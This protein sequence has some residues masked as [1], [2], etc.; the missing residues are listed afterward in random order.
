[1]KMNILL[2]RQLHTIYIHK[3]ELGREILWQPHKIQRPEI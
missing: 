3:K 1:M 2:K